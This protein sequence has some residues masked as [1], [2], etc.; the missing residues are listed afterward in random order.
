M[1]NGV[2]GAERKLMG[3]QRKKISHR[4]INKEH[5]HTRMRESESRN[6]KMCKSNGYTSINI[7]Q[8]G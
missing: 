3:N 7:E 6:N 2:S 4:G 5:G 1:V 8:P